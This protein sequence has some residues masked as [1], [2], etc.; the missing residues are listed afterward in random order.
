MAV[1]AAVVRPIEKPWGVSDLRQWGAGVRT[2]ALIGEL[3]F[4]RRSTN[5]E[6]AALLIKVLLTSKDLSVQVHPDDVYA[7]AIGLP[8]GKTE[9]WY[10]LGA[11]AHAKVAVGLNTRL[12]H[13]ELRAAIDDGSIA[14]HLAWQAVAADDVILIPA[15]TIHA[16]G[17]G[18]VLVEIQQNSDTTFR[19]LDPEHGRPLHIDHAVAAARAEPAEFQVRPERLSAERSLLVSTT[20]FVLERVELPSNS[21]WCLQADRETWLYGLSGSATAERHNLSAGVVVVAEAAEVDVRVGSS[22]VACLV[23]YPGRQGPHAHLLSRRWRETDHAASPRRAGRSD[24]RK[25]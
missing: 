10:I 16:I 21:M 25:D 8:H 24:A 12:T 14:A 19:I 23:A 4:E 2:G 17:A 9:A 1:E 15:G 13:A 7:Q 3:C 11:E 18:I 20:H 5:G 6:R 22:G